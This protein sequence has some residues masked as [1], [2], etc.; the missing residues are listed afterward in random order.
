MPMTDFEGTA[1]V[2]NQFKPWDNGVDPM[3]PKP[4]T[5]KPKPKKPDYQ[6]IPCAFDEFRKKNPHHNGALLLV[7][8]CPKCTRHRGTL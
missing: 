8:R 5:K 4:K 3:V 6:E 2:P 1:W 7:C